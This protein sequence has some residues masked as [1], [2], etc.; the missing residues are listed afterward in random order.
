M[1]LLCKKIAVAKSKEVQAKQVWQSFKECYG[2]KS[3]VLPMMVVYPLVDNKNDQGHPG[4]PS[5]P[6]PLF[7]G[8]HSLLR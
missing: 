8:G 3:A 6:C 1:T 5:L 7:S 2:S 4:Y